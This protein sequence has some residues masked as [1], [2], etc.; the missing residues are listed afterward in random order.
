MTDTGV[1]LN[2]KEV[3]NGVVVVAA[4][5]VVVVLVAG[6]NRLEPKLKPLLGS[7]LRVGLSLRMG[8]GAAGVAVAVGT[9]GT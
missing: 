1:G 3:A 9:A 5:A 6:A 4:G 7:E 8:A 2:V